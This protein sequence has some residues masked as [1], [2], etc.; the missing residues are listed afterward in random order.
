MAIIG[1]N[2]TVEVESTLGTA[3]TVTGVTQ[4]NP[5]VVTADGTALQVGDVVVFSVSAGMVELDGQACRIS[6]VD[7]NGFTLEGLDTTEYST[8]TSGTCQE[9][10]AWATLAPAQSVSMPNPAPAKIDITRLIDKSKQ[11]AYGLP[12]APDGTISGLFDPTDAAVALIKTAT[13]ANADLAFRINFSSGEK[14]IF[15]ANVS[16]GQGFD[17]PANAAATATIQFTPVKDVQF[18]AS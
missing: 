1:T 9:V 10:T 13:K 12:E 8:W 5:G 17:L 18:Y 11:Y 4:A 16:G 6:A 3:I 2:I 14:V 7:S 15:N